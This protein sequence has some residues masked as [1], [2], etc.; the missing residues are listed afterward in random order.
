L[1]PLKIIFAG[2]P[3]FAAKALEAL[4]ASRHQVVAV[5]TQPDRPAGRGRKLRASPVKEIAIER[6]LSVYQPASLKSADAQAQLKTHQADLMVVAA[7]GLILPKAILDIPP[8][9]CLNI[10]ASLLPRWRGAAPIQRAILAG[11]PETGV[12]I[13]QMDAGLDT[14]DM[15][16]K[17]TCP[18]GNNMTGGE[19]HDQ[20]A[21]LGAETLLVALD[22][23]QA[24]ELT[25]KPQDEQYATYANKLDKQEARLDWSQ[26]AIQL[27]RQ[28]RAFNPWPV[29]QT[30]LANE[31]L[32][33]WAAEPLDQAASAPPG[34][35][36]NVA[37]TGIDVACGQGLLR[38]TRIQL[39]GGKPLEVE[40]VLNGHPDLFV[41]GMKIG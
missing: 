20:L 15:L 1:K 35:I 12:T 39:P 23:L 30:A 25:P 34:T 28:V 38:L 37:A 32:R 24:G 17:S 13:M 9:G 10:H 18:I 27:H 19:L 16:L 33:V 36:T 21:K 3:E 26:S 29:A 5:Y 31:I 2:T 6:K 7:Y 40:T 11:D 8:L 14:G 4:L 22:R 41:E